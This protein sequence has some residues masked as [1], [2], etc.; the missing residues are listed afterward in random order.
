MAQGGEV[1]G[2]REGA[3]V[4]EGFQQS[5]GLGPEQE[6]KWTGEGTLGRERSP[7]TERPG[8]RSKWNRDSKVF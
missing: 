6:D 7:C 3:G 2:A 1:G 4:R 5:G 8:G